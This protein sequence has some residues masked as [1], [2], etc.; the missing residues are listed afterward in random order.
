MDNMVDSLSSAYEDFVAAATT[1]LEAKETSGDLKDAATETAL[2]NFK[3]KW[4]LF[5]V[6]CDQAEKFVFSV[7]KKRRAECYL[8]SRTKVN[9]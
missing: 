8:H 6:E 5:K 7:K 4:E 2:R 3:Q 1:F 9:I